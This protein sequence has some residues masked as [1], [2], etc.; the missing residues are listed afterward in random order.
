MCGKDDALMLISNGEKQIIN[1]FIKCNRVVTAETLALELNVSKKTIYRR[2]RK[3]NDLSSKEII[4]SSIGQGFKLDYDEYLKLVKRNIKIDDNS[5]RKMEVIFTLLLHYPDWICL[6]SIYKQ[7][8][9]SSETLKRDIHQIKEYLSDQNLV[10]KK[11]G[12]LVAIEGSD[13]RVRQLI[14]EMT[15]TQKF[16]LDDQFKIRVDMIDCDD[17]NFITKQMM[18]LDEKLQKNIPYPYNENIF[19]HLYIL[20][21]RYKKNTA[22]NRLDYTD[23]F[24]E[25]LAI[26][27]KNAHLYQL[28]QTIVSNISCYIKQPIYEDEVFYLFQYLFSA[29]VDSVKEKKAKQDGSVRIYLEKVYQLYME[30]NIGKLISEK[31][32]EDMFDH[33]EMMLYRVTNGIAIKNNLLSDI[34]REY[35]DLHDSLTEII[36]EVFSPMGID[37]SQDEIGFLTIY[38]AKFIEKR[39]DKIRILVVCSS[40][41]GTSELLKVKLEKIFTNIVIVDV[42][43][44]NQF[45][46]YINFDEFKAI[47]LVVTT[48]HLDETYGIP[49]VLVNAIFTLADKKNLEEKLE[50]LQ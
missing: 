17:L 27:Q 33:F 39:V 18:Y 20:L 11:E 8:Y 19:S 32:K 13:I 3:I 49:S 45:T 46:K 12:S 50:E 35:K 7:L 6:D 9:V 36:C 38:F 48:I 22:E 31:I 2:I 15:Q 23:E 40:G 14:L 47:D 37:V 16:L 34:K 4:Q 1:V 10:L 28:S 42:L 29:R 24:I 30:K 41:V 21:A 43:S 25:N 5:E 44:V 26:M